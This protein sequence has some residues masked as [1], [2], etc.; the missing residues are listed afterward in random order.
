MLREIKIVQVGRDKYEYISLFKKDFINRLKRYFK[1][2][3]VII[4]ESRRGDKLNRIMKEGDEIKKHIKKDSTV[5]VLSQ[6]GRG[7][8]SPEFSEFIYKMSSITFVIGG[9]DG[10][11]GGVKNRGDHIIS[12]SN[13][14]FPHHIA[15][16]LL[17]EQLYRAA[18][19][20][21]NQKYH[22]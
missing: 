21:H 4:K 11:S 9:S 16:I 18:T 2:D 15:K 17:L 14:T 22:K 13:M 19:I 12:L 3:E 8:S 10:L 1:I 5:I 7:M 20:R 6:E